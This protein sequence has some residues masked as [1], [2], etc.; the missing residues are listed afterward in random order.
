VGANVSEEYAVPI[1]RVEVRRA[2]LR[3]GY[4]GGE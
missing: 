4:V 1:S 3:L 2:K